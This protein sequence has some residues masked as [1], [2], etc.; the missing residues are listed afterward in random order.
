MYMRPDDCK[1][2]GRQEGK[3]ESSVIGPLAVTKRVGRITKCVDV[4]IFGSA[5]PAVITN[6]IG[7]D[8]VVTKIFPGPSSD[9]GKPVAR[10]GRKAAGQRFPLTAGLPEER[11]RYVEDAKRLPGLRVREIF[12]EVH[13]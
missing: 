4:M 13:A 5:A 2:K 1:A 7:Y 3:A 6:I 9:K 8:E 11:R 10:R 12:D